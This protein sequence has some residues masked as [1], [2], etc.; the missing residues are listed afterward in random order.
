MRK[1]LNESDRRR[2]FLGVRWS[3]QEMDLVTQHAHDRWLSVSAFIRQTV[4]D[5][6]TG[7]PEKKEVAS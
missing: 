7:K 1:R 4:M 5:Q 3:D 2:N 6:L